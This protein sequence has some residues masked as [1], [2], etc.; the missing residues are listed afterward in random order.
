[1][2]VKTHMGS[3]WQPGEWVRVLAVCAWF[4]GEV[5]QLSPRRHSERKKPDG[6]GN[7][8]AFMDSP[9]GK[10]AGRLWWEWTPPMNHRPEPPAR[11]SAT[12]ERTAP[13]LS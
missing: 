9:G 8:E 12:R 11:S 5:R 2:L 10:N 7:A 4:V 1:M 6:L 3:R 13:T